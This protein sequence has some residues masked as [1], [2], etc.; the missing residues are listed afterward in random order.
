M[1]LPSWK[2]LQKL[3]RALCKYMPDPYPSMRRLSADTGIPLGTVS[4]LLAKAEEIGLITRETRPIPGRRDGYSYCL[5]FVR[6]PVRVSDETRTEEELRSSLP[7]VEKTE[8]RRGAGCARKTNKWAGPCCVCTFP[9]QPG[10]GYLHGRLPVHQS[11]DSGVPDLGQ[12]KEY[13]MSRRDEQRRIQE[14]LDGPVALG[15]NP[16]PPPVTTTVSAKPGFRLA[17]H[18]ESCWIT[19][20]LR[21]FPNWRGEY[22]CLHQGAAIGY[23]NG[24]FL[25]KGFSEEHVEAYIDAFY[26]D[27][28]DP[29]TTLEPKPGQ[30]AWQLFTGWWGQVPVPDPAIE[31]AVHEENAA[32]Q[33][34]FSEQVAAKVAAEEEAWARLSAAEAAGEAPDDADL[35]LLGLPRRW[36]KTS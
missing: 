30:T 28:L 19:K 12:L 32:L 3:L 33:A 2:R 18:F 7:S 16:N 27:L 9:V 20:A 26:F 34:S 14:D 13:V 15:E 35:K 1:Y 5:L 36:R 8:G 24:Q 17:K 29:S 10:D 23:I 25:D 11:C 31:R 22:R 4:S 21:A 6:N